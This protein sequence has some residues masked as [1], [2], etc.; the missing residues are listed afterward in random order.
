MELTWP[1]GEQQ[2]ITTGLAPNQR[3]IVERN[4]PCPIPVGEA[5]RRGDCNVDGFFDI[6]DA[7]F[8]LLG[9]YSSGTPNSCDDACDVNDD[10]LLDLADSIH[11]L[12]TLFSDGEAVPPPFTLCG[13]DPT[14]DMLGCSSFQP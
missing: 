9:V 11:A 13:S 1:D 4:Q 12:S 10:G 8:L 5:F 2:T 7:V 14:A 3:W 6:E